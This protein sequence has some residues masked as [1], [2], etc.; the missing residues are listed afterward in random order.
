LCKSKRSCNG[1]QRFVPPFNMICFFGRF[2]RSFRLFFD[3]HGVYRRTGGDTRSRKG[4]G[5]GST[6]STLGRHTRNSCRTSCH[7]GH[8]RATGVV[9]RGDC[10]T[11]TCYFVCVDVLC[12]SPTRIVFVVVVLESFKHVGGRLFSMAHVRFI[13]QKFTHTPHGIFCVYQYFF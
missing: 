5:T 10:V 7:G 3:R 13:H 4:G 2:F 9:G 6:G 11:V 1:Y 8:F 12:R